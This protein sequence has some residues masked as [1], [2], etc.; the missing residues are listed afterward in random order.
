MTRLGSKI[1]IR[2]ARALMAAFAFIVCGQALA[3]DKHLDVRVEQQGSRA[4]LVFEASECP[5]RPSERGCV[6]AAKGTS[7]MISWELK[8]GNGWEFTRLQM[9]P[10]GDHWG[11]ARHPLADCTVA[12]FGL[13]EAERLSGDT[14]SQA[15]VVANGS[16]LQIRDQNQNVCSTHYRLYARPTGGGPEIDSDPLIENRGK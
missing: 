9:S 13:T 10:D 1:Q 2:L 11:D 8:D 5:G 6:E 16:M 4:K 14:S 12:D 3:Q 15:R 7:P